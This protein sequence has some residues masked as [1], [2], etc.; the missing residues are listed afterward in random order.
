MITAAQQSC[1]EDTPAS[2]S[3]PVVVQWSALPGDRWATLAGLGRSGLVM[4]ALPPATTV[5][6]MAL[7][8]DGARAVV[9]EGCPPEELDLA[10]TAV[11]AGGSYLS[12]A[13]LAG[14][15]AATGARRSEGVLGPREVETLRCLAGGLTYRQAARQ[16]GVTEQTVSTYAKRLRRKLG[17]GNAAE[18]IRRAVDLGYVTAS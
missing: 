4:V 9:T 16:L 14:R 18:L 7:L 6:P 12:P 17:A 15:G 11:L 2:P 10:R 3:E 13:V 1:W 5:D 8:A